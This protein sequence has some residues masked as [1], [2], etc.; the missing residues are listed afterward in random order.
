M[1][2]QA[3][4]LDHEELLRQQATEASQRLFALL[5]ATAASSAHVNAVSILG[6]R[7]T[8]PSFLEAATSRV[9]ESGTLA[10]VINNSQ[11]VADELMRF[12]IFDDV[13]VLLDHAADSDPLAAP[14]SINV[15]YQV[16]EKSR[17]YIKTGTEIGNNEGNVNG[18]LTLRNVFGGGEVLDSLASFGTRDS[19]AFQFSLSSP[20]N[21]SPNSRVDLNAHHVLRNN[22]LISSYE[23][24]ARGAG[25]R[26]KTLSRF[27]YHELS[28]DCTW[29]S[30]DKV[31]DTASLSIRQ[32]AGHSLKSSINH[33][34]VRD[35]RDDMLLPS[36]GH[37]IR[38]SQELAGVFGLGNARFFK[39]E[40]ETQVCHQLGGGQLLKSQEGELLGLHPGLVFSMGFR[41]GWLAK[42]NSDPRAATVSDRFL[43]G[44]P[45]SV[46]GFRNAGLGPHDHHDALG[47]D[48]YWATGVSAMAPVPKLESKPLR[49]HAFINAGTLVPWKT[50]TNAQDTMRSL[51]QSP[52]ISVGLGLIYRH[53]IARIELNYCI[54]LTAARGDHV[55]RGLQLGLGLNFL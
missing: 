31:S 45:L 11:I 19:S 12:D 18:S 48:L 30:I 43:L 14:G 24:L 6:A 9:L 16:K 46:R 20:V 40:L 13:H 54:P 38:W 42:L 28:Y 17:M 7:A 5:N 4:D 2:P 50:T 33:V 27:G 8:R 34:F 15:L 49:A 10:D 44:G 39:T 36:T 21:A 55:K 1:P 29:R 3:S 32:Q 26:L 41:A 23:E 51:T 37:Y 22:M 53:S 35:R 52:S 47:G 25:L